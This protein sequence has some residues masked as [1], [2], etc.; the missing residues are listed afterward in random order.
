M[1][2]IGLH[3]A[4]LPA[5]SHPMSHVI[6]DNEPLVRLIGFIGIFVGMALLERLAPA[7]QLSRR[8]RRWLTNLG[9]SATA[10]VVVYLFVQFVLPVAGVGIAFW[11]QDRNIG[12]FNSISITPALAF[13]IS[14]FALDGLIY[15]Q[16][17]VFHRFEILWR[18]HKVHHADPDLDV[19]T[20]VRFHP[21]EIL[22]SLFIKAA[23][24]LALGVPPLA[25]IAFEVLLNGTA[26]FNHANLK[27]GAT[28]N[29]I[30][31]LF[32]VTPDMHRVHH[33]TDYDAQN[34]N[35]GFNLSLWDRVFGTYRHADKAELST[36]P[37]G[38]DEYAT[39]D[40]K[41]KPTEFIWSLILPFVTTHS[42][43]ENKPDKGMNESGK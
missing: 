39:D 35:F 43:T 40:K 7:R 19:T 22:I 27:L 23:A 17:V 20:A 33:A 24:I 30:L 9:L 11:A 29:R 1:L 3:F 21:L 31:S 26:M 8:G 37:V 4:T 2:K 42:P 15:G 41:L 16:H 18:M 34:L 38:L 13:V 36:M 28:A 10:R 6:L 32:I 12:L 5:E 25:V 14:F